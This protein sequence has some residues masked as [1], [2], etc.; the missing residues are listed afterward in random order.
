MRGEFETHLTI[1]LDDGM[2]HVRLRSWAVEHGLKFHEIELARGTT[3]SQPMIT[4]WGAGT[5]AEQLA[6]AEETST[7]LSTGGFRVTRIKIEAAP[8]NDGVPTTDDESQLL[9]G[10][11]YFEH[12]IKVLLSPEAPLASI[13]ELVQQHGAHL[14]RNPRR[15]RDD[16]Q[17]ERFITQR[18][19][20]VGQTS[21]R[22]RL[23]E[24]LAEIEQARLPVVEVEQE[25]V[26]FDS[27]LS[28]DAGW[29]VD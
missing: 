26:V 13:A 8:M 15:H 9:H 14:S 23:K 27:N 3:P 5:L 18:C 6:A 29:I 11:R 2:E 4:R 24:L 16:G 22:R 17:H 25:F 21:A 20:Q 12:H 1:S 19:S 28:L 7:Q 10:E